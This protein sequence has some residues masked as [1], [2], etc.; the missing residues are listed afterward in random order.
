MRGFQFYEISLIR[1]YLSS[2]LMIYIQYRQYIILASVIYGYGGQ[3]YQYNNVATIYVSDK[4]ATSYS[5]Y[6]VGYN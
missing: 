4:P 2:P 5:Y 1:Q 3:Q 6:I